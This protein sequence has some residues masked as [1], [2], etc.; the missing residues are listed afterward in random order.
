MGLFII[1]V[2]MSGST[3]FRKFVK[4]LY[5]GKVMEDIRQ[6]QYK[7]I[8]I[9]RRIK[10]E[11]YRQDIISRLK[12]YKDIT[13]FIV[14]PDNTVLMGLR[15]DYEKSTI[16]EL[17][18]RGITVSKNAVREVLKVREFRKTFGP[19]GRIVAYALVHPIPSDIEKEIM[20]REGWRW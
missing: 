6:G 4:D 20:K 17:K 10:S 16:E 1:G 14:L 11:Q 15:P 8:V 12:R 19:R 18:K 2:M 9:P 7:V 13:T 3:F 5:F